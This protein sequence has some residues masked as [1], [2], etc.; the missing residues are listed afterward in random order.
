MDESSTV[1]LGEL[2]SGR[3]GRAR[4]VLAARLS[5]RPSV[6]VQDADSG[7]FVEVPGLPTDPH[8]RPLALSPAGDR[9][10]LLAPHEGRRFGGLCLHTLA[11]GEQRW[12]SAQADGQDWLAGISP[13]GRTIAT[14]TTDVRPDQSAAI[15]VIDVASGRRRRL[16]SLLPDSGY[17]LESRVC[18]SP[19]GQLVAVT[20]LAPKFGEAEDEDLA[21]IVVDTDGA[22]LAHHQFMGILN[23]SSSWAADRE[24]VCYVL[25]DEEG[26]YLLDVQHNTKRL[27]SHDYSIWGVLDGRLV[28]KLPWN[29]GEPTRLVTTNLDGTDQQ[30]L[31]AIQPHTSIELFGCAPGLR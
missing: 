18:W 8:T 4:L 22:V 2:P 1:M 28:R 24:L 16:T 31:L 23:S 13:D 10:L 9:L 25:Y 19:D 26:L 20:Y 5:P 17:S 21:T 7:D 11:T 15:N 27:I 12:F 6:V 29:P 3:V 30:P 14:L